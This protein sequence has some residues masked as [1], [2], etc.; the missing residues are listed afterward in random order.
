M[1]ADNSIIRENLLEILG[2]GNGS[3]R[4]KV[5]DPVGDVFTHQL[6]FFRQ[7]LREHR[8]VISDDQ[9]ADFETLLQDTIESFFADKVV[10]E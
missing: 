7:Q 10:V 3:V 4:H 2:N 1:V 9:L 6:K 5:L 8:M